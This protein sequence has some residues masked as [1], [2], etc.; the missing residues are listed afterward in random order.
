MGSLLLN[1]VFQVPIITK[2]LPILPEAAFKIRKMTHD[3]IEDRLKKNIKL[4][5]FVDRL[6]EHKAHCSEN[7]KIVQ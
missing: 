2:I 6:K 3:L 1:L 5:D 7:G 4:G